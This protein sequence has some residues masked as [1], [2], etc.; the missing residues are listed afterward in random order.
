MYATMTPIESRIHP[1][2]VRVARVA[3]VGPDEES[4]LTEI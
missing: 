2:L 4:V 1:W 3:D